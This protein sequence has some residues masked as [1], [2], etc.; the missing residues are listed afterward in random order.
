MTSIN[1]TA[2]FMVAFKVCVCVPDVRSGVYSGVARRT[3]GYTGSIVDDVLIAARLSVL[4]QLFRL[5][6]LV[7]ELLELKTRKQNIYDI[8]DFN[9][10]EGLQYIH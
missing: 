3:L 5:L 6:T 7:V 10:N 2:V 9:T 1:N 8:P 4:V